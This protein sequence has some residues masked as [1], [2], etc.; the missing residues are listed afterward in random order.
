MA[1]WLDDGIDGCPEVVRAGTAAFGL[2]SRCGVWISRNLTDGFVPAEVVAMYGTPEWAAKL[3]NV[4]LWRTVSGGFEDVRYHASGNPTAE[5][6]KARRQAEADR[7]ARWRE[8]QAMSRW[9]KTRDTHGTRRGTDAGKD[10][11]P[12][13]PKGGGA[14]ARAAPLAAAECPIHLGQLAHNCGP[15]RSEAL[16]S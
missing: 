13:P 15:C 14:S 16:A 1:Y 2:Y 3:V 5:K 8:K 9:D 12:A 7:K 6:V 4:G 11:S 10:G